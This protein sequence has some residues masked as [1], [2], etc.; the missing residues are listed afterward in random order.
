M[1]LVRK[2]G[3]CFLFGIGFVQS[4]YRQCGERHAGSHRLFRECAS[5]LPFSCPRPFTYKTPIEEG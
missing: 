2:V 3:F 4:S 1:F 5:S